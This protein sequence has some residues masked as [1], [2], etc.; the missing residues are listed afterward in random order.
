MARDRTRERRSNTGA[1]GAR[2]GTAGRYALLSIIAFVVILPIYTAVVAAFKPGIRALKYPESLNPATDLTTKTLSDAWNLGH[3]D[4]YMLNSVIVAIA[5][6]VGQI[7]TSVL[8]GY[9]FANLRFPLKRVLFTVFIA[10]LTVPAEVTIIG[11]R[12]TIQKWH[13]I[14]S[15]Q[16]LIVPF[17]ATAFGTFL[18]RQVFLGLPKELYDAARL[19]GLGHWRYLWKIA[20]PLARPSI[21]A[22]GVFAFLG[23]WNQYLWPLLVTN[24]T[25]HRTVQVGLKSLASSQLDKPNLILAGSVIAA[26][27]ILVLLL[28]FQRQLVRGLT[29]GAVKG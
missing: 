19:D 6:M 10:T 12:E 25:D 17:L 7:V 5:I 11:N 8:A 23:A 13:W 2:G 15:Y 24:E 16:A 27:P 28:I 22:L 21:G 20:V 18:L 4:R 1:R 3:L 9:A 29:A 26:L 14:D